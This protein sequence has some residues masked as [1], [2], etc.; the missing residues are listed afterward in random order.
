[1]RKRL[2]DFN[3]VNW[4]KN[5]ATAAGA[6]AVVC[7]FLTGA[8]QA[9]TR[10]LKLYNTHTKERVSITFKKN[11]RYLPE[12][13]REANR[14]LRDWRRN[15]IIKMDPELLDLVWEVYQ[16]VRAREPINVVSSYR[17]P[18][19]NNMLR[20]RSSGVAKNSQHTLG[21]AM[22][23]YIPGVNL[24]TLRATGLRKEVGGVGYYPRSGSPFVHMDTG[25][26]RHWPR[27]SRSQL[28]KVFPDGKTLHIPSD[29]KP[30]SGYKVALAES[31]SGGRSSSRPTIVASN[32]RPASNSRPA[33]T[34]DQS[35]TKPGTPI[36]V[37]AA[38]D[39][40]PAAGGNLFASLFGGN[41]RGEQNQRPG[42][43]GNTPPA[44]LTAEAS[45]VL[46]NP[47][48]PT[49]KV[50]ESEPATPV[51]QDQPIVVASAEP[52]LKPDTE[53]P[54]ASLAPSAPAPAAP[55]PNTLDAQR[56]ALDSG[57]PASTRE[58][59]DTR[60]QVARA[61]VQKPN[62]GLSNAARAAA[63]TLGLSETVPASDPVAAIAAAT[64]SVPSPSPAPRP[65]T[66]LAYA[67][68]SAAPQSLSR[69]LR[70]SA[71]VPQQRS[72][73]RAG[74][75]APATGG[76]KQPSVSGRIPKDQIIDPLAGFAS[77][78]D[79]SAATL[80][81]GA[82]TTRHQAF[83]ALSHPNQR[84]LENVMMPGNRFVDASFERDPYAGLRTDRF[85]GPAIVVLPVR[86][87]R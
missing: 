87:A 63:E 6:L 37:A 35:L 28:A 3:A 75:A 47:P 60:F 79:K 85:E 82:G 11:G 65:E 18:A 84:Q 49:R 76:R 36:P 31:R 66:T 57:Q 48:V 78:P 26:I 80:L 73:S 56:F 53:T 14:F 10:T 23:F 44:P 52:V 71:S 51:Q 21:K 77:L 64:G 20:K 39:D 62:T 46:K 16:N 67:S 70:P 45:P 50:L 13:L 29:G 61:P 17:S 30:M 24:A 54:V 68:A 19:T 4:L 7:A 43:V 55:S 86:F 74:P 81:S 27:M 22:D 69:S 32:D 2:F 25:N 1:M 41:N 38:N 59:I 8:A 9:E 58:V 12:G 5:A 33:S 40:K 83:A 15:E 34:R 42:A 72:E